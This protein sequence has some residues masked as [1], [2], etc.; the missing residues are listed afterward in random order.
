MTKK[1][2]ADSLRKAV[3]DYI[4]NFD[5]YGSNPQ[6]LVNPETL[7]VSLTDGSVLN[8]LVEDNDEAVEDAAVAHG[9]ESETTSDEQ[10]SRNPD[11]YAV[12]PLL[13]ANADGTTV[14][15]EKAVEAIC[16]VYF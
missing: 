12:K 4:D 16:A 11:T 3:G 6:L 15:S 1:E 7:R 10:A 13:Q 5:R 9:L 2:F 8:A 14:P